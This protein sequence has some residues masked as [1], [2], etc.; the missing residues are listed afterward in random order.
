MV[1]L[2]WRPQ[3]SFDQL[4][5]PYGIVRVG[6][7]W[8]FGTPLVGGLAVDAALDVKDPVDPRHR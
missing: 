6:S 7:G 5:R 4:R 2:R 3:A 1:R 8:R